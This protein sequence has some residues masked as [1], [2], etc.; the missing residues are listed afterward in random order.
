MNEK[1]I[2][3]ALGNVDN[4]FIKEAEPMEKA[5]K[6]T[7]W[8]KWVSVAACFALVALIGVGVF[9]GRLLGAKTD[10][11]TLDS[12][13]TITFVKGEAR[14]SS[15]SFDGTTRPLNDDEIEMLFAD[16]PVTA[17][18]YFDS[19][20]NMLGFEGKIGD[21]K[22]VVSKQGVNLSDTI[23]EGDEL[24]SSVGDI[25]ISAGYFLTQANSQG[26]KTAIYY[27]TFNIGENCVYVEYSG[28]ES[29]RET[30][31]DDLVETI[32]VLI[33]NGELDLNQIQR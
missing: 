27:A 26:I 4:Q 21:T 23:V 12:G 28:T 6:I 13:E 25:D 3:R 19:D 15:L 17:N 30:V 8:K 5:N 10:I 22:L 20:N 9:Q 1:D 11:A 18:A 31:K 24:I 7:R 2:L 14:S 33:E 32:L 16:L 29:E